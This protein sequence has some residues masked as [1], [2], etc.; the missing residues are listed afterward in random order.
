MARTCWLK[1]SSRET[2]ASSRKEIWELDT[3]QCA[4]CPGHLSCHT[5]RKC[6]SALDAVFILTDHDLLDGEGVGTGF[7]RR[8]GDLLP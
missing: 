7:S 5:H 6:G 4:A 1:S 3:G 2:L 8:A